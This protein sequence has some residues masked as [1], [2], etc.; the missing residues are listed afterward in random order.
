MIMCLESEITDL[1]FQMKRVM[2]DD[3]LRSI[4]GCKCK[5]VFQIQIH[6]I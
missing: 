1:L 3:K 2:R 6:T 5:I 4:F